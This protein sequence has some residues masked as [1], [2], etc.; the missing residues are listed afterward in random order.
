M[1]PPSMAGMLSR[2]DTSTIDPLY[3]KRYLGTT[4]DDRTGSAINGGYAAAVALT[5]PYSSM[6]IEGDQRR[7]FREYG[8]RL[9]D[10][11]WLWS[12]EAF[13]VGSDG[14][15]PSGELECD[16]IVRGGVEFNVVRVQDDQDV[17]AFRGYLLARRA[18]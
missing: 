11:R 16:I 6:S 12:R 8:D 2:F 7:E 15:D 18:T 4:V 13:T 1:K 10:A 5:A 17:T 3:V 14:D 9:R